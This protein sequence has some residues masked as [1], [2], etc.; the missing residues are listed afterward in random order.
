MSPSTSITDLRAHGTFLCDRTSSVYALPGALERLAIMQ[1][2]AMP[3]GCDAPKK[4][5]MTGDVVMCGAPAK[6]AKRYGLD[7]K[8]V[9]TQ[10]ERMLPRLRDGATG[11]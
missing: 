10:A 2:R 9:L 3:L 7:P 4:V 6:V 8:E 1:C 5:S 11:L